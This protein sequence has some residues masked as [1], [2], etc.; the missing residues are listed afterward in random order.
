MGLLAIV[1]VL[2]MYMIHLWLNP[3][4]A[5]I[6]TRA[7]PSSTAVA[8]LTTPAD[9]TVRFITRGATDDAALPD[10]TSAITALNLLSKFIKSNRD[11]LDSKSSSSSRTAATTVTVTA[12]EPAP[13]HAGHH[14]D[15]EEE[16]EDIEVSDI[17][18]SHKDDAHT[19]A[20]GDHEHHP[21]DTHDEAF[22]RSKP[23]L[24]KSI[25]LNISV[26]WAEDVLSPARYAS[27]SPDEKHR[28]DECDALQA[29]GHVAPDEHWGTLP[30]E[31]HGKFDSLRCSDVVSMKAAAEY[32]RSHAD[33]YNRVWAVPEDRQRVIPEAG[34]EDRVIAVV[35][36]MTT[37][38]VKV[39]QLNDLALFR[40]LFPSLVKTVEP[41]FEYWI[42]VGYDKGDPWLDDAGHLAMA[43]TWFN[44]NV[45]KPLLYRDIIC[46]LVFTTFE[47][48]FRR[49]GPAFNFATGVAYADG[50]TWIYRI[51]D[52]QH[53]ETP[54]AKIM[55][56]TLMAM[57]PP[58]GVVGV[59]G[60]QHTCG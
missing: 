41:G 6:D 60:Q 45:G 28:E 59:R 29:I 55:T 52:D 24:Y 15:A 12:A 35:I 23:D 1:I 36:P 10:S 16:E 22:L 49:P 2:Q 4:H 53:F 19:H 34:M 5:P 54:W 58:Y 20:H 38:S 43:R 33:L 27:L 18:H 9:R 17:A 14:H 30:Q 3:V 50:A 44:E 47:N 57:G 40:N 26:S 39:N 46:K 21:G 56:D 32:V 51:N 48:N 7:C 37:R 13:G 31:L 25:W 8:P 11:R 42:Y